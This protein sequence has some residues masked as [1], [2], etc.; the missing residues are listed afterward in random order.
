MCGNSASNIQEEVVVGRQGLIFVKMTGL[1]G[2]RDGNTTHLLDAA[3][4]SEP[5]GGKQEDGVGISPI[6]HGRAGCPVS[7]EATGGAGVRVPPTSRAAAR[8]RH[9]FPA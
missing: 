4:P 9:S 5:S 3:H 7:G 1:S 6:W 2:P 8:G